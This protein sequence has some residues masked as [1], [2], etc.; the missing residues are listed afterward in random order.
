VSATLRI[1]RVVTTGTFELD[2][3]TWEVGRNR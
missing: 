3:G 1:E 2:G